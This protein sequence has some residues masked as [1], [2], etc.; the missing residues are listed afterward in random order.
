[1]ELFKEILIN[2]LMKEDINIFFP[3]LKF[4]AAE[5]VEFESF[6]ALQKIKAVIEDDSLSDFDCI[7]KIICVFEE[8]GSGGGNR[9]DFD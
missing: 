2:I 6:S 8:N 9:H 1:M 7:E 3:N 5:I 4:S